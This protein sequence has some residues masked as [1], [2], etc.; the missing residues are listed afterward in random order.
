MKKISLPIFSLIINLFIV[1]C[2]DDYADIPQTKKPVSMNNEIGDSFT[3][4]NKE[5]EEYFNEVMVAKPYRHLDVSGETA[6]N[7]VRIMDVSGE[8]AQN[9]VRIMDVSGETAQNPVRR[10]DVSGETAQNPV[11]RMDVSRK[12]TQNSVRKMDVS[13]ETA[14]NPVR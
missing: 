3:I 12:N 2:N 8:T 9:P 5:D 4:N 11:R 6:Q 13:G 14:Q 7:P 10:M 1:S